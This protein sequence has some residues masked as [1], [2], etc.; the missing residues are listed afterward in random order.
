MIYVFTGNGK[1]KTTCALG[2]GLR[3]AGAG[4]RVF[5]VQF[6]KKDKSSELQSIKK[7][8]NFDAK[9]FGRG[10]CI[11]KKNISSKDFALAKQG[12]NFV[13]KMA[14]SKKYDMLILDELNLAL[15]F[16]LLEVK[17]VL[18]F[19]KEYSKQIDIVLTGRYCP[20][21]IIEIADLVTELKEVKHYY[22][23]GAKAR[24]GIEY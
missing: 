24:K 23:K 14:E 12:F 4:L 19:L 7:V 21:E 9:T 8:N 1:G 15:K 11:S 13:E 20:K 5:M 2:M 17:Q 16:G 22:K 3:A 18:D 6:L 10:I